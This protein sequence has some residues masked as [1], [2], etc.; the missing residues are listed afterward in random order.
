[1]TTFTNATSAVCEACDGTGCHDVPSPLGGTETYPCLVCNAVVEDWDGVDEDDLVT[2]G[3]FGESTDD[4]P[5]HGRADQELDWLL[6]EEAV[7]DRDDR[8]WGASRG[9]D[10]EW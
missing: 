5:T 1:M 10:Y 9:Y 7:A 2:G 3:P 8:L 4:D 6:R